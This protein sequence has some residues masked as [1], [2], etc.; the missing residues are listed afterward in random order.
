MFFDVPC[1]NWDVGRL[2][3]E[4]KHQTDFDDRLILFTAASSSR[5]SSR[6]TTS[7]SQKTVGSRTDSRAV[8]T[9]PWK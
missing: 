4:A 5:A 6:A 3:Y 2:G 7:A 1:E 9:K 8:S